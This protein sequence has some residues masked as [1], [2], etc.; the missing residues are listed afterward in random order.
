[1]NEALASIRDYLGTPSTHVGNERGARIV[2]GLPTPYRHEISMIDPLHR[3]RITFSLRRSAFNKE[4]V[5]VIRADDGVVLMRFVVDPRKVF[6]WRAA[7]PEYRVA[8]DCVIQ[9]SCA[10]AVEAFGVADR[11][12]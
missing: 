10:A 11:V 2:N 8:V 7:K 1:M 4:T 6:E 5:E 12:T 9:T 3:L